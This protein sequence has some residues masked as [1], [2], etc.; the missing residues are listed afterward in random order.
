M[1]TAIA[2]A[3]FAPRRLRA[4][5]LRQVLAHRLQGLGGQVWAALEAYGQRRAAAQMLATAARVQASQPDLA[6]ELRRAARLAHEA[7]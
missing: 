2:T 1:S 7:R 4:A 5:S 6:A 3:S